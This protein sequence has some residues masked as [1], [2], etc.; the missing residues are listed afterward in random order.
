MILTA[1]VFSSVHVHWNHNKYNEHMRSF[2]NVRLRRM[3]LLNA[4]GGT[5]T[6]LKQ[7]YWEKKICELQKI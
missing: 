1:R 4:A 3:I 2:K 6:V 5:I 7:S